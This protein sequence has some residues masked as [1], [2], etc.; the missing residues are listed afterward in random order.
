MG[1]V[2]EPTTATLVKLV[3]SDWGQTNRPAVHQQ[4]QQQQQ[5]QEEE[6]EEESRGR[7]RSSSSN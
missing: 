4:Q 6:E 1:A 3:G 7:R 2:T 5:Q